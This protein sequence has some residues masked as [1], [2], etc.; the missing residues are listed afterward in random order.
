MRPLK[1]K[2]LKSKY[3]VKKKAAFL[4][5]TRNGLLL[6]GF[7]FLCTW[8]LLYTV[9]G[10]LLFC[11]IVMILHLLVFIISLAGGKFKSCPLAAG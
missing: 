10:I 11:D 6:E 7:F 5:A 3:N 4:Y 9:S 1:P 2:S 8:G